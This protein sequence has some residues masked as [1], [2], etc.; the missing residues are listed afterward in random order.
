MEAGNGLLGL[1]LLVTWAAGALVS[2]AE[3]REREAE[4]ERQR[5]WAEESD[6]QPPVG[7]G[8]PQ[9]SGQGTFR[10]DKRTGRLD[11]W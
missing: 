10:F 1:I 4:K 9:P 7:S 6:G 2:G 8:D 11:R 3:R 5:R